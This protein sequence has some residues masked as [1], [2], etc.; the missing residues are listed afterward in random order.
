[1][2]KSANCS[3]VSTPSA[4]T[5]EQQVELGAVG[6][7]EEVEAVFAFGCWLGA[8]EFN[9]SLAVHS[10]AGAAYDWLDGVFFFRVTTPRLV[11]GI[12]NLNATARVRRLGPAEARAGLAP[13]AGQESLTHG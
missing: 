8:G 5:K 13:A 4:T 9:V 2:R 12:A 3:F 1:M 10:E 7:G 6:A 11:E